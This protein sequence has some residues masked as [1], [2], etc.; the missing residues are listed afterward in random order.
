[1]IIKLNDQE[2]QMIITKESDEWIHMWVDIYPI[3]SSQNGSIF[4]YG[5]EDGGLTEDISESQQMFTQFTCWRGDWDNR[6]YFPDDNEYFID[7]MEII[8]KLSLKAEE[9]CK[10]ILREKYNIEE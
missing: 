8:Y 6:I 1:M 3:L 10:N 4:Y 9:L 7:D 5:Y 2:Y